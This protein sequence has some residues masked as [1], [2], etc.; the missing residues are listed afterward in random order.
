MKLYFLR[1]GLA[2]DRSQWKGDDAKRPL[3]EEGKEKMET[4]VNSE[5]KGLI[6]KNRN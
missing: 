2:G 3:T 6:R 5:G 4:P 1:H